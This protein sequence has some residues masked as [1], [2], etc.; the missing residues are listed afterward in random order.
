MRT[1]V[2]R[3]L[4]LAGDDD[5]MALQAAGFAA[6]LDGQVPT[7]TELAF[8]AEIAPDRAEAAASRLSDR[9]TLLT[10]DDGRIEAIAGLT[11]RETRHELVLGGTTINTWCAFDSV[12]IPAALGAD[13][14]ARTSCGHCGAQ[15]EVPFTAGATA[16]EDLWGWIPA[17][18]PGERSL[19]TNFCSKADLFCSREHLDAWYEAAGRPDGDA[20]TMTELLEMGRATWEHCVA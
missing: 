13:A 10:T 14:V 1:M 6:L 15:I 19:M 16:R 9:E 20:C 7:A 2:Q 17:L 11:L 12:G 8:R 5:E 3:C 18:D 4:P